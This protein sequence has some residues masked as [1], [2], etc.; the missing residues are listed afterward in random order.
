MFKIT[1]GSSQ[2]YH[3][4]N[5]KHFLSFIAQPESFDFNINIDNESYL[6]KDFAT[7]ADSGNAK[8][9]LRIN[10]SNLKTS[11]ATLIDFNLPEDTIGTADCFAKDSNGLFK[12]YYE[13]HLED[14]AFK[15]IERMSLSRLPSSISI[16]LQ[17]EDGTFFNDD[18]LK[19]SNGRYPKVYVTGFYCTHELK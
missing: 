13:I 11:D 12:I 2:V 17:N 9:L 3:H 8:V 16:S 1:S 19:D 14:E 7:S 18:W 4:A 6:Q 5:T 10:F 15:A